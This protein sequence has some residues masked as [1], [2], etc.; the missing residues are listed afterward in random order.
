MIGFLTNNQSYNLT[1]LNIQT[2][3]L[4]FTGKQLLCQVLF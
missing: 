1:T 4:L 3:K 2:P